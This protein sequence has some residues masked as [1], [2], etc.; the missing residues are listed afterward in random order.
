MLGSGVVRVHDLHAGFERITSPKGRG[1][2]TPA[3]Q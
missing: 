1:F 3:V 2:G